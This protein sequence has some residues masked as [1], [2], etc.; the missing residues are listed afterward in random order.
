MIQLHGYA[1]HQFLIAF[2][3]A[4]ISGEHAP[5]IV[6][7]ESAGHDSEVIVCPH[8]APSPLS[9]MARNLTTLT[10][11][12]TY[13]PAS[14]EELPTWQKMDKGFPEAFEGKV[15]VFEVLVPKTSTDLEYDDRPNSKIDWDN[16]SHPLVRAS[17]AINLYLVALRI[18]FE[19][20]FSLLPDGHLEGPILHRMCRVKESS[21]N[22]RR[23]ISVRP[24]NDFAVGLGG[25]KAPEL[26]LDIEF[27]ETKI[28]ELELALEDIKSGNRILSSKDRMIAAKTALHV[29][30]DLSGAAL[31]S[32]T[33]AEMFLDTVLSMLSWE[34]IVISE[35]IFHGKNIIPK[36][37]DIEKF[38]SQ[39][40]LTKRIKSD[41]SKF[42][43][44]QSWSIDSGTVG[45]WYKDC[46][47]LR[48]RVI[49]GGYFPKYR[50]SLSSIRST[51]NLISFV[52]D[53]VCECKTKYPRTT[54]MLLGEN[55]L[56]KR[57]SYSNKY[58]MIFREIV[59]KEPA[60]RQSYATYRDLLSTAILEDQ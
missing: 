47:L 56:L 35:G 4:L 19:T 29:L 16:L 22:E 20:G 60:W 55:G 5:T 8:T 48:H 33:A 7:L 38:N 54:W 59:D 45:Q 41:Y 21:E 46:Y 34:S 42:L 13:G 2:P 28:I 10:N 11:F 9:S 36:A 43:G 6:H 24:I 57:N 58:K 53:S 44:G 3:D 49:H 37:S 14:S 52:L 50:E 25:T 51:T 31:E 26:E 15:T 17:R 30:G 23:S 1:A 18:V 40:S 39:R 32:A 12:A 27:N